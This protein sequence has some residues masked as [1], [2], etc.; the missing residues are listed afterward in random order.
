METADAVSAP[1]AEL[2]ATTTTA[3]SD[4]EDATIAAAVVVGTVAAALVGTIAASCAVRTGA[5]FSAVLVE[6]LEEEDSELELGKTGIGEDRFE[7]RDTGVLEE[8]YGTLDD[9]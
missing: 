8:V 4:V 3:D 1:A 5:T 9:I 6:P 2:E 7:V